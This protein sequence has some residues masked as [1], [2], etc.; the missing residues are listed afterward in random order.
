MANLKNS[1][2]CHMGEEEG[3]V[4]DRSGCYDLWKFNF[5][6]LLKMNFPLSN[7]KNSALVIWEEGQMAGTF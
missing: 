1:D 5:V 4:K 2:I 6:N 3:E 7:L